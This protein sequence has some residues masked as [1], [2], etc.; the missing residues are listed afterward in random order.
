MIVRSF[1]I[2]VLVGCLSACSLTPKLEHPTPP[3]PASFPDVGHAVMAQDGGVPASA[4]GW[5]TMFA[6]PQLQRLIELA[7]VHNRDLRLAALNVEAARSMFNI[8]E[9]TR[10]PSVSLDASHTRERALAQGNSGES[11]R[12]VNRQ[13]AVN[14]GTSA[15]E[16]DLFGR[17]RSLSDAALARYL[18][19]EQGRDAAQITLVGAVA[20]AYFAQRLADEQLQLAERTRGDWQ[21]SLELARLLKQS[22]QNSS[23]DVAQ[24]EGQVA[25]AEADLEARRRALAQA[26]NALQLLVGSE[27]PGDLPAS[28]PLERQSVIAQL[29]AGLPA[30]LLLNRPDLRQAEQMLVAANADIGAARAAFFPQISLT[31]SFGYAST[32]LGGLF[33]PSRQVWRFTPQIS[34]PLFQAGRL[35]AELRL[36]KVRK[37]EAVAQYE[38]AIQTA[39][40]EVADALAG[41]ATFDRQIEAQ[42]RA[43]TAAERRLEL[44]D[45]RYRAGVDGRLELLDAQ[46]QL[47]ASRLALLELRRA[48][49]ANRVALFKSLGG[50]LGERDITKIAAVTAAQ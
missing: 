45:L 4:M 15:F 16:L 13:V 41:T 1:L 34:Q 9:S 26:D 2:I 49:I 30:D 37:S 21:Q 50:G 18:A 47:Q 38:R 23:L 43:V 25:L 5:R 28:L 40:R 48:E 24:A 14:V 10:L 35:R 44:S 6:D 19:S 27:L 36:A 8:Q 22:E 11:R 17:V 31:A 32:S 7:L 3:V 33:D 39:F 20:E 29:P 46:R 12:E 42:L